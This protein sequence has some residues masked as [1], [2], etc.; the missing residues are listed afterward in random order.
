[1]HVLIAKPHVERPEG[2]S[3][4]VDYYA[5]QWFVVSDIGITALKGNDGLTVMLRSVADA[6]PMADVEIKLIARNNEVLGTTK[7]DAQGVA[8]F[9]PGL[10]RGEG[11]LSP[12]IVVAST[13][14]GDYGFLDLQQAAF[15]FTDRGVGGRTPPTGLDAFLYT[16]RGVYRSGETVNL[17]ALLR[18]SLASRSPG[19]RSPSSSRDPM[20]LNI[21][22]RWSR[23][24]GLAVVLSASRCWQGLRQAV[25]ASR[26]TGM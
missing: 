4:W 6:A 20:A 12:G 8:R 23:I 7:T 19:A 24:R 11:G 5:T 1:M 26:P 10:S 13:S 16:E 22:A 3:D 18:D 9:D 15:D 2:S 21:A 17:T 14:A 25:G